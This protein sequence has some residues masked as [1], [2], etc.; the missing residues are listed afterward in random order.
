MDYKYFVEI[1]STDKKKYYC[2][3]DGSFT[4]IKSQ[5]WMFGSFYNFCGSELCLWQ[6]PFP[7][8]IALL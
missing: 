2:E 8:L 3:N 4:D 5:K 1:K 6:E 7:A